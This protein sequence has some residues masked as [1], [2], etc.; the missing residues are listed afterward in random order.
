MRRKLVVALSAGVVSIVSAVGVQL[1]GAQARAHRAVARAAAGSAPCGVRTSAGKYK[2][3]IVIFM[4]NHAYNSIYNSSSAPYITSLANKCGLAT[5]YHNVTHPS[6]PNYIAATTGANYKQLKPFVSD[7]PPG[8]GVEWSGN[9]IFYQLNLAGR[10]WRGYAE[11]MPAPCD[12]TNYGF[13][14]ARHN[15]AVYD[16]DLDNCDTNDVPLGSTSSSALLTDFASSSN[17]PAYSTVTPNLCNDMHDAKGCP[18]NLIL[19]GNNWLKG[20]LPKITATPVYKQ[21]QTV[22]FVTWDEGEPGTRGEACA[23]NISDQG[24]RVVTIVVAPSVVRGKK[25]ATLFNHYSL[26][27]TSEQ[28]LGLPQIGKAK[29]ANSMLG[30]FNL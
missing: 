11:T 17:A 30:P 6:L 3:V 14:A 4:E 8:P 29:T 22:I 18:S 13:Y 2:H 19:T 20:W 1:A 23:T 7:K 25:V 15:P 24:C 9:N 12:K 5:N 10:P 21:G 27:K 28:L 16:T 26:L